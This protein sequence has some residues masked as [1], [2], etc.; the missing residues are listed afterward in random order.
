MTDDNP[1]PRT[2]NLDDVTP[3]NNGL[4]PGSVQEGAPFNP[5]EAA[6]PDDEQ[7]VAVGLDNFVVTGLNL[8]SSLTRQMSAATQ[9]Q[10]ILAQ[11]NNEIIR[12]LRKLAGEDPPPEPVVEDAKPNGE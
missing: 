8:L 11:Q 9:N 2:L 10:G 3:A 12:L 4:P 1:K 7:G 6:K 5:E